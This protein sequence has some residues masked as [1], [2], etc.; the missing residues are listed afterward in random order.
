MSIL[1]ATKDIFKLK[2]PTPLVK[3]FLLRL[4]K[5]LLLKRRFINCS[6]P[7]QLIYSTH[8]LALLLN[9]IC[10][11]LKGG[12]IYTP[13]QYVSIIR[14]AKKRGDPYKVHELTHDDFY[15]IKALADSVGN[16]YSKN[17]ENETVK[18]TRIKI[19][20]FEA[21]NES[22][23]YCV[24]Y[25]TQDFKEVKLNIN[26]RKRQNRNV[27]IEIQKAYKQKFSVA[28]KKKK[29]LLELVSKN[30]IPRFYSSF[31]TNL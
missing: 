13:D 6:H 14:N 5:L 24:S 26:K 10:L 23:K 8:S 19:L 25:E 17:T 2:I 12:P 1:G 27:A 28:D 7:G 15:D 30:I 20:K 9:K 31:Y 11:I 18:I 29:G 22:F 3:L 16:N 4:L 21:G